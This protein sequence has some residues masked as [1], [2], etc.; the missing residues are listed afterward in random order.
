MNRDGFVINTELHSKTTENM[1][2]ELV[3]PATEFLLT[4]PQNVPDSLT[5]TDHDQGPH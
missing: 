4:V 1:F 2:S 3:T 5:C